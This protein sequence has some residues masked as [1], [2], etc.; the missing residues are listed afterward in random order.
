MG[1]NNALMLAMNEQLLRARQWIW[2]PTYIISNDSQSYSIIIYSFFVLTIGV[3]LLVSSE[4]ETV[5]KLNINIL[6]IAKI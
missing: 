4:Q 5:N 3:V 2:C 6:T 1:L